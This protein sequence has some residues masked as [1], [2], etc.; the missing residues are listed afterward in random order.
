MVSLRLDQV[1]N[2]SQQPDCGTVP[3]QLAALAKL[4]T[5]WFYHL[6]MCLGA[7]LTYV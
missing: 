1:T 6:S 2:P 5:S 3:S 7:P 4:K